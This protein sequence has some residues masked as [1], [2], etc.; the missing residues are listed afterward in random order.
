MQVGYTGKHFFLTGKNRSLIG[1]KIL[2][3]TG[4]SPGRDQIKGRKWNKKILKLALEGGVE[5]FG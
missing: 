2:Y 5:A 3:G 4:R 1:V